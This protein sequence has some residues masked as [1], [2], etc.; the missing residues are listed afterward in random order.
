MVAIVLEKVDITFFICHITF[1]D[2]RVIWNCS[3]LLFTMTHGLV[4][5]GV[6]RPL[7]MQ[8][9]SFSRDQMWLCNQRE[10]IERFSSVAWSYVNTSLKCHMTLWEVTSYHKPPPLSLFICCMTSHDNM[11]KES[12]KF[13]CSSPLS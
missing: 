10:K 8:L 12:R 3:C 5:F 9:F 1:H 11:S 4:K 13:L 7:E 2:R 6:Y